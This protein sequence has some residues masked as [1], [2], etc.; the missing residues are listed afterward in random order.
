MKAEEAGPAGRRDAERARKFLAEDRLCL[1]AHRHVDQ[2]A[3]Q[4]LILVKSRGVGF[5]P[6]L[7]LET[8]LDEVEGDLRQAALRHLVQVFDIDRVFDP[9]RARLSLKAPILAL[10]LK[11]AAS[12]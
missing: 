1:V 12:Q 9:H 4:Q 6:A 10:T 7:V 8:A 11:I 2:V 5:E 3:R